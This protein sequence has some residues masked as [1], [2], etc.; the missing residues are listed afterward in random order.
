MGAECLDSWDNDFIHRTSN[1]SDLTLKEKKKKYNIFE[2]QIG[3]APDGVSFQLPVGISV[4][5]LLGYKGN[6]HI[7]W[8]CC[9]HGLAGT[10]PAKNGSAMLGAVSAGLALSL[11]QAHT[12]L[13]KSCRTGASTLPFV[14]ATTCN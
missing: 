8:T 5:P 7:P 6:M 14:A 1:L 10:I 9:E 2:Y 12:C 3:K 13:R 4:T 11:A